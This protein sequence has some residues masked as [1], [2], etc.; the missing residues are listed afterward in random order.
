MRAFRPN[1]CYYR[2]V[3]FPETFV[4]IC[5][6]SFSDSATFKKEWSPSWVMRIQVGG[7]KAPTQITIFNKHPFCWDYPSWRIIPV[8]TLIY[9]PK[10]GHLEGR[11]NPI[12]GTY[13]LRLWKPSFKWD[14]PPSRF[15]FGNFLK[16]KDGTSQVTQIATWKFC[17]SWG[18]GAL[19]DPGVS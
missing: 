5:F 2:M 4:L 18:K 14:E 1:L 10:K 12:E 15:I 19:E 16:N 13:I 3:D 6:G 17:K 11:H 7:K 8:C 9:K